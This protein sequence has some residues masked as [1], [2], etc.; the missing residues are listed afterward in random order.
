MTHPLPLANG[1]T[2]PTSTRPNRSGSNASATHHPSSLPATVIPGAIPIRTTRSSSNSIQGTPRYDDV[3]QHRLEL[4]DAKR[5]NERL[6]QR[7]IELE[8]TLRERRTGS[9][10][11]A[12]T[13][14]TNGYHGS[15]NEDSPDLEDNSTP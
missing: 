14:A 1:P 12:S 10:S 11:A 8:A 2:H 3:A 7:V 4:E 13:T 15:G 5:E 9:T 6:R